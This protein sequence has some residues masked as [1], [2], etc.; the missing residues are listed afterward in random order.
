MINP[1]H[2]GNRYRLL[3]LGFI[4]VSLILALAINLAPSQ[5]VLQKVGDR[6]P[7][8]F[9]KLV[10]EAKFNLLPA[11]S[12][13]SAGSGSGAPLQQ[14]RASQINGP[15]QV[16]PTNPRYFTDNSGKAIYLTGSHTWSNLQDNGGSSPPPAFDYQAYLNFL[17]QNNHNFFRLWTWEQSRWTVE[18][19]DNNYWFNP[20]PY[21]R[22]GPGTALDGQAKFDLTKFN[23]AY[24]DRM[25]QRVIMARDQGIYVS[26]MLFDGWSIEKEKGQ[27]KENNPW[28]GHPFN[29]NNNINGINGDPNNN[30][31]GEETATLSIAEITSI[32]ET[33]VKKVIDT[34]NDLDNV[35]YE[36]SNES[37]N[38][39]EAWQYHL[40][41]YIHQYE[42]GKPK[43]HPVGMTSPWPGGYNPDLFASPAEWISPNN[44]DTNYLSDPPGC[45]WNQ[46]NYR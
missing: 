35:L 15:L 16:S 39:S 43:Q 40:I 4:L 31:S 36:I 44:G 30:D 14:V 19:T 45:R 20:L 29:K 3:F 6:A 24:F 26:I 32:Q 17:K 28:R 42:T 18:T 33:Y 23:Q 7:Q 8:F 5:R 10:R 46:G 2:A 38:N 9:E 22:T 27:F 21:Q 41:D 12:V 34:V 13:A 1:N 25:R 11:A 37:N